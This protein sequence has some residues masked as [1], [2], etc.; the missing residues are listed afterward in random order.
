MP[1]ENPEQPPAYPGASSQ[2]RVPGPQTVSGPPAPGPVAGP[3]TSPPTTPH[4][5]AGPPSSVG[6]PSTQ[7]GSYPPVP[8]SGPPPYAQTLNG[9]PIPQPAPGADA[10]YSGTTKSGSVRSAL[11]GALVG[12]VVAG[13]LV[14]A[15]LW[16]RPVATT[17]GAVTNVTTQSR[18]TAT[19]PG[20]SLD[21]RSILEKVGPSV[22]SIHTGSSRGEAAGSGVIINKDGLILTNAHVIEG[23]S[24]INVEFIDGRSA[25][26][27]LVGAV[28]ARDV[29]L[30]KVE[31][32]NGLK[33][34]DLGSS[35]DLQVGDD[36]VAIG[37]ALNLGDT[38]SVTTGIVSALGRSLQSPT[39]YLL[40]ALI[41]TDAAINPGN[42]GGPLVNS[43]GQVVGINTAILA[44]AQN[45]GFS[46]SIDSI[47]SIIEDVAAGREVNLERPLLGVESLDVAYLDSQV[48][49]RFEI[50]VT[51]GAFIQ[52]VTADSGAD[53]AGLQAG[54]VVTAVDG[55]SIRSASDLT[56]RI[57]EKKPGDKVEISFERSGK[58]QTATATLGGQ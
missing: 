19:I 52:R 41:Q 39:G 27:T 25:Q 42:S 47:K 37:N 35:S 22:V 17:T 48:I 23:A 45:I 4:W 24:A 56:K 29:A 33:A 38:P 44:D 32:V 11:I 40:T 57:G 34:A 55:R 28:E 31:G 14:A 7:T 54:D 46:L 13:L 21:L 2:W 12:A 50:D 53:K 36:V 15:G 58:S 9:G 49:S 18:P 8:P 20:K 10:T 51:S 30:I 16:D 6:S 5:T 43:A 3:P 1:N 26:A